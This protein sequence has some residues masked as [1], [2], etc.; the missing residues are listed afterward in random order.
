MGFDVGVGQKK[1]KKSG[2]EGKDGRRR[3]EK[4]EV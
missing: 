3:V 2:E 4:K 1:C